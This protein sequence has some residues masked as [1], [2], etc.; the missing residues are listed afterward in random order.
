MCGVILSWALPGQAGHG[1]V[2]CQ[3]NEWVISK[4]DALGY[5]YDAERAKAGRD[6]A[7]LPWFKNTFMVFHRRGLNVSRCD[8]NPAA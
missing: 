5:D 3:P 2:N 7:Q 6:V 4:M 1:H 8:L